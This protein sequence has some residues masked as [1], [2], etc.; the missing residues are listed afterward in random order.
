MTTLSSAIKTGSTLPYPHSDQVSR[1]I[2]GNGVPAAEMNLNACTSHRLRDLI[3]PSCLV[4]AR[5]VKHEV[6]FYG[7][8]CAVPHGDIQLIL[9]FLGVQYPSARGRVVNQG[10]NQLMGN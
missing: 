7:L 9:F 1:C 2:V 4:P 5:A 8:G 10:N 6:L 3:P